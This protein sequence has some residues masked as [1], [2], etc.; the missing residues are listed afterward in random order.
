MVILVGTTAGGIVARVRGL[1][2]WGSGSEDRRSRCG[3]GCHAPCIAVLLTFLRYGATLPSHHLRLTYISPRQLI[4]RG[5]GSSSTSTTREV[6]K[7]YNESVK[8][9]HSRHM[10][11]LRTL[12]LSNP[13]GCPRLSGG[14]SAR[15]E[16]KNVFSNWP[17]SSST[18]CCI[19]TATP[20]PERFYTTA[21]SSSP[22]SVRRLPWVPQA[23][24]H[25][26]ELIGR[27]L[28]QMPFSF[29]APAC[30]KASLQLP[31]PTLE[32]L[33]VP[34]KKKLQQVPAPLPYTVS[35]KFIIIFPL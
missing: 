12:R 30:R 7:W 22:V 28:V 18:M 27:Q 21:R 15:H 23:Q 5:L 29:F 20:I 25:S 4:R 35:V 10:Y 3:H 9:G 17:S 6:R 32:P 31:P 24:L 19:P 8:G 1:V 14:S 11:I 33:W 13:L 26:P 2:D 16:P 34:A